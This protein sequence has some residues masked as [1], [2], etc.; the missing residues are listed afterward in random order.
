M[1][2]FTCSLLRVKTLP[3]SIEQGLLINV[4]GDGVSAFSYKPSIF[5][6]QQLQGIV[7]LMSKAVGD[8][9]VIIF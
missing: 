6:Q 7:D 5:W 3:P 4:S 2:W 8:F 9:V 1:P